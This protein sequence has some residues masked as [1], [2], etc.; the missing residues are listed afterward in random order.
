M[1]MRTLLA[2][3]LLVLSATAQAQTEPRIT[4]IDYGIVSATDGKKVR[5]PGTATGFTREVTNFRL[6]RQAETIV[7]KQGVRFGIRYRVDGAPRGKTLNGTCITRFPAG[8]VTN[9]K[10]AKVEADEF[11]CDLKGGEVTWRSYTFEEPWELVAG[12]WSL[13]F[14]YGGKKIGEKRFA[15]VAP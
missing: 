10:G 11:D 9:P 7:A 6:V 8:G 14:W 12:D 4:V 1:I 3:V 15:V 13:E 5:S 2:L